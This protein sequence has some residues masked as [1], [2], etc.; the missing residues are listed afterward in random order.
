ML[1]ELWD[2]PSFACFPFFFLYVEKAEC[3]V[4]N[5]VLNDQGFSLF[6]QLTSASQD[7]FRT[8]SWQPPSAARPCTWPRRWSCRS[9]TTP[10]PISGAWARS[11]FSAWPEKLRSRHKRPR[12]WSI[13]TRRM[14][15]SCQSKI[16]FP[17]HL[18]YSRLHFAFRR[19]TNLF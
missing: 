10:R 14:P 17:C 1:N 19:S 13:T 15:I 5:C 8:A 3:C 12:P 16:C 2:T 11:S 7:S 6:L 18:N 9:S 4:C